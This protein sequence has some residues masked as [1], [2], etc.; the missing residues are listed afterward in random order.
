MTGIAHQKNISVSAVYR[1]LKRFYQLLNPFKTAL[2][3]VLHFDEFKSVLQVSGA[4]IFIILNGQTR[5]LFDIVENRQPPYLERYFNSFT[6]SVRDNVQFI[7]IDRYSPHV[8]LVN[9]C[10]PSANTLLIAS[11]SFN[12]SY[13]DFFMPFI[14]EIKRILM[15]LIILIRMDN[16]SV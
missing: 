10:F 2:P 15:P 16:W 7:V 8:S 4:M 5:K 12:T 1:V 13:Q 6:L 11:M 3:T 14:N 9:K